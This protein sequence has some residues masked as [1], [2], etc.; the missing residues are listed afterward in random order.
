MWVNRIGKLVQ[1]IQQQTKTANYITKILQEILSRPL[2]SFPGHLQPGVKGSTLSFTEL[3]IV[4][5]IILGWICKFHPSQVQ[6]Y[7]QGTCQVVMLIQMP[8]TN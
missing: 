1:Q 6:V 7:L 3:M 5:L 4:E 8:G 2:T